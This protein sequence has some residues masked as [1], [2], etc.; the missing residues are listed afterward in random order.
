MGD[1]ANIYIKQEGRKDEGIYLYT[2][3]GGSGLPF[4]LQGALK[5]GE[6][7]WNDE[8]YLARIIFCE[9]IQTRVMDETG[10]GISIYPPDNEYPLLVVDCASQEVSVS[11]CPY[12]GEERKKTKFADFVKLTEEEIARFRE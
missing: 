8:S 10:Y 6:S 12:N 3:S 7:R 5:R 4:V 9:M 11:D 2:R 1:R